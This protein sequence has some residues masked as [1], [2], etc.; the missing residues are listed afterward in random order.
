MREHEISLSRD[1]IAHVL[2]ALAV[3][4]NSEEYVEGNPR[5][6]E[7]IRATASNIAV[8]AAEQSER[9]ITGGQA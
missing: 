1:E 5:R 4:G 3:Y 8:Q 7:S 9:N 2:A 6:A